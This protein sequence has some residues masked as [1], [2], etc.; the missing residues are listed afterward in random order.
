M[1]RLHIPNSTSVETEMKEKG[2]NIHNGEDLEGESKANR[3]EISF[4]ISYPYSVTAALG[5]WKLSGL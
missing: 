4:C 3:Q 1:L 5:L 2:G